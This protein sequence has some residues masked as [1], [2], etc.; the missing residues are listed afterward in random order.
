MVHSLIGGDGTPHK[1]KPVIC[2]CIRSQ[3]LR[4]EREREGERESLHVCEEVTVG[5]NEKEEK[6]CFIMHISYLMECL[7]ECYVIHAYYV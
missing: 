5:G 7:K 4:Q 6:I 1:L 2:Q 3:N